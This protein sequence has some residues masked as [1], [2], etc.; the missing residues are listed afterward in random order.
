MAARD[1]RTPGLVFGACK[2]DNEPMVHLLTGL[3][4]HPCQ[5]VPGGF[6]DGD[7]II[8]SRRHGF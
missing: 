7:A 4:F 6:S 1:L 8:W 5:T 3:G 2:P